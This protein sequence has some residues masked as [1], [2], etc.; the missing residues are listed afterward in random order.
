MSLAVMIGT[1]LVSLFWLYA[2]YLRKAESNKLDSGVMALPK[3]FTVRK[4][5]LIGAV[6]QLIFILKLMAYFLVQ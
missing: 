1:F 3:A 5:L 6:F 4:L 2:A